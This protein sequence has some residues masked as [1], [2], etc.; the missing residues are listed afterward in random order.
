MGY[1]D[2]IKQTDL[3]SAGISF[4]KSVHPKGQK[5]YNKGSFREKGGS[6]ML[7]V[8][9]AVINVLTFAAFGMDKRAAVHNRWRTRESTLLGLSAVGGA[10]GG[11]IGMYVFHHKTKKPA[12]AIGLPAMIVIHVLLILAFY[13]LVLR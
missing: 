7:V 2:F 12:F 10:C 8:Y 11:L 1:T 6:R 5:L 13:N 4:G 9:M 3:A